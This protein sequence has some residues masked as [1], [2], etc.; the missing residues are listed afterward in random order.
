M[1]H[2]IAIFLSFATPQFGRPFVVSVHRPNGES[3]AVQIAIDDA[4]PVPPKSPFREWMDG[5][6]KFL[7]DTSVGCETCLVLNLYH[8]KLIQ[9]GIRFP[10]AEEVE[11]P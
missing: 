1:T 9:A 11:E 10:R 5:Q 3:I 6:M 4:S 8:A 7:A 2:V